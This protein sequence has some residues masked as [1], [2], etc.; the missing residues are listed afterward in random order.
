M[1][2][3]MFFASVRS[4]RWS[5]AVK[6]RACPVELPGEGKP[7]GAAVEPGGDPQASLDDLPTQREEVLLVVF[8]GTVDVIAHP[9]WSV[10]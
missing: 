1:S 3:I 9:D 10:S 7:V 4:L 2:T 6:V 8:G 5:S